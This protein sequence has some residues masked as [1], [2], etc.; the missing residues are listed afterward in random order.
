M[1]KNIYFYYQFCIYK[2]IKNIIG[3]TIILLISEYHN[4]LNVDQNNLNK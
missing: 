1:L 2:L 4:F 3:I